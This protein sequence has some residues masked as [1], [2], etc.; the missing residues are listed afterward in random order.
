MGYTFPSDI[1]QQLNQLMATG[2]FQSED[3]LIRHAMANLALQQADLAAVA[4]SLRD[5]DNGER[6]CSAS[7][8]IT[9]I[10]EKLGQ[11]L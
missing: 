5:F 9:A 11:N 1:Q 10:R 4:A 2:V 8:S 3:D 6:G 7:D